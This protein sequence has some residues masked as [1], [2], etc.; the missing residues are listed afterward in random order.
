MNVTLAPESDGQAAASGV[1]SPNHVIRP[2]AS[3]HSR[4]R[5]L[6]ALSLP[7]T[8]AALGVSLRPASLRASVG[9]V[10]RDLQQ[11]PGTP[12]QVASDED[13][14]FEVGRAFTVDRTLVNL[15]N[16]GVSPSPGWVQETMK[17][18]LD[19]SNLAPTY[20]MWG[21]LEPQREGV[22]ERMAREWGVDTE[23]V[24]FTRNASES[25]QT[26]QLGIDLT[27]GDEVLTT[28]QD[29]GRMITTFKQ[30]ERREGI[31]LRQIKIPVPVEDPGEVVRLFE[32][33]I[34]SRTR[35][36]LACHMI[37]LTGQIL[38]VGALNAMA[39]RHGIP[40]IVDGAHALGHFDFSLAELDVDNYSTSLHKWLFAPHGTGMLYVRR[41][42]ISQVWPLMAAPERMDDDIRKFEEIGTHPAANY[43][44]I[45]E[46]LTFHQ[47]IGA[48]RKDARL[49]YLR[50]YWAKPLLEHDRIR[51]HTSLKPGMAC[52][53]ANVQIEGVE[54][55]AL[56]AWLWEEHRI[57]SVAINHDEFQG[58]RVSPS[59][60]TR[61]EELDRFVDA[62]THVVE[63][64]LPA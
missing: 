53:I 14:W 6:G 28:T 16:G 43:L 59:V 9:Q 37:N 5:F 36:I 45:G 44:A 29:Y 23:E 19:Y 2:E 4:R 3:M 27:P 62:M 49:V 61:P 34:T 54:A 20:T 64:G 26:M 42:K 50:D 21:I 63:K 48:A 30:R 15:N 41:E 11:H 10:A 58:I 57:I 52:G 40:L 60:Y 46:A 33:A 22:R 51:L 18:H 12:E 13:F 25:L 1:W 17:R 31:V 7:A 56:N 47:G 8:A 35:A 39:R 38:P 32:E 55:S 24:A